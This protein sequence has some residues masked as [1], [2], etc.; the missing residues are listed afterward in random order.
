VSRRRQSD[1]HVPSH[2]SPLAPGRTS[3][4]LSDELVAQ[5]AIQDELDE[6][7][8][9]FHSPP[10][11]AS[12]FLHSGRDDLFSR[13]D[14]Q[15]TR[16]TQSVSSRSVKSLDALDALLDASHASNATQDALDALDA[17]F[18]KIYFASK[19]RCV[20]PCSGW[21]GRDC[22]DCRDHR[23]GRDGSSRTFFIRTPTLRPPFGGGTL[24]AYFAARGNCRRCGRAGRGGRDFPEDLP[25][26]QSPGSR[27]QRVDQ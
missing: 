13:G 8:V 10:K 9:R 20:P 11:F 17:L 2:P 4:E 12:R 6:L 27:P 24:I 26:L 14:A 16:F 23:D 22:R 5:N 15:A 7:F 21:D 19:T 3:D 1:E 25:E 18:P